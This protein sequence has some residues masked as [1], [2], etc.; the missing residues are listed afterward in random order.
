[1]LIF[2]SLIVR[3]ENSLLIWRQFQIF[4]N[5]QKP[6]FLFF[7]CQQLPS[8][9][10]IPHRMKE[11]QILSRKLFF[12]KNFRSAPVSIFSLES[13]TVGHCVP[14]AQL[15]KT[16]YFLNSKFWRNDLYSKW[17]SKKNA[18]FS[19]FKTF[20]LSTMSSTSANFKYE[21]SRKTN[22]LL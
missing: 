5:T 19:V 12:L 3:I 15:L 1:M 10:H 7:I 17:K 20:N 14:L 13:D 8:Y 16:L 21:V 9:G 22:F 4:E 6:S 2:L 18:I 11:H